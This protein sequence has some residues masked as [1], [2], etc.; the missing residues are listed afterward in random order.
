VSE[1][2]DMNRRALSVVIGPDQ[3]GITEIT[4]IE[5]IGSGASQLAPEMTP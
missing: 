4:I 3:D 1:L 2:N 5:R